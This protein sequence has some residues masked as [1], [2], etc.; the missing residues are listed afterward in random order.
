MP[1]QRSLGHR[2]VASTISNSSVTQQNAPSPSSMI[3]RGAQPSA[4][5]AV[6]AERLATEA[7]RSGWRAPSG[8]GN[9]L[10]RRPL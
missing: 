7:N 8:S 9:R 4:L 2:P 5:A 6:G 3:S 10:R 1:V